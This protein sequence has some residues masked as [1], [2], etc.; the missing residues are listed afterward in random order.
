M[1][2]WCIAATACCI[3]LER[4]TRQYHTEDCTE[5]S[6]STRPMW[7]KEI[8]RILNCGWQNLYPWCMLKNFVQVDPP[9]NLHV[10]HAFL[11]MHIFLVQ[12]SRTIRNAALVS[13]S[14]YKNLHEF[15]LKFDTRNL[16]KFFLQV[17]SACIGV[18][19]FVRLV[20]RFLTTKVHVK[21]VL[22]S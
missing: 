17:S 7:G 3:V 18:L 2:T 13:T 16:R 21:F 15:A 4:R 1:V 22:N 8:R 9:K 5:L 20:L 10:W 14:L 19:S 12:V 11:H 6:Y